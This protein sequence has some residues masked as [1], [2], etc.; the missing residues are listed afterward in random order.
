MSLKIHT[1]STFIKKISNPYEEKFC[2]L[3]KLYDVSFGFVT[4]SSLKQVSCFVCGR[5]GVAV[6]C[7][8]TRHRMIFL[9]L[10]LL[11]NVDED[12]WARVNSN[13]I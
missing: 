13:P 4:P 1:G 11:K 6:T 10:D 3:Y 9:V 2:T 7:T 5:R 12:T 8:R